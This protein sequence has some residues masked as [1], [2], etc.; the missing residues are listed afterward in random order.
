MQNTENQYPQWAENAIWYQIFPERFCRADVGNYLTAKYL[1]GTTPFSLTSK[2]KWQLHPW[3]AD[4]Y[5]KQDY[6]K[7]NNKDL[8]TNILRRRFG[9]NI[10]GIINK[11]DYLQQLGINA[12]YICPLQYSPSLHKYDGT[13]FLHTDPFFGNNPL[14]DIETIEN[15]NFDDF[16]NATFTSADLLTLKLIEEAHK[17]NIK[18]IFDGVFNHIGYNSKP[19][20]DV[21]KN[22]EKSKYKDWFIIDFEK[23]TPK[24]LEYEKFWGCVTEMPKL[25]YACN[26]VKKYVFATLKRWLRPKVNGV[27]YQGIDGWRI[28][29]AIGVPP[30]FWIQ[31]RKFV[32]K[33]KKDA[34]FLAELIEP[35]DVI[36]PYLDNNA[37][38]TV[39]NYPLLFAMCQFF[40][41]EDN[42]FSAKEFNEKLENLQQKFSIKNSIIMQNLLGSHDTERIASYIVNRKLKKFGDNALFWQNSHAEDKKYST[43]K[44]STIDIKIQKLMIIFQFCYIGAPMIYYGDEAGMWGANDPDCRKPMMWQDI[45]FEPESHNYKGKETKKGYKLEF[46]QDMFN[47]YKQII[48]IRKENSVLINGKINKIY[49]SENNRVFIF[50][51]VNSSQSIICVLN[52]ETSSVETELNIPLPYTNLLNNKKLTPKNGKILL[53]IPALTGMI[54][55]TENL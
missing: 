44:P 27:D 35:E 22:R 32:K 21:L 8:K 23:S 43:R 53:K 24:K 5:K 31:A 34:L 14:Q 6:E 54:L 36:K 7:E 17:R 51:R 26:D 19:F 3:N 16:E 28:D 50:E 55:K 52:R 12:I 25:N 13:N 42:C 40:A 48:K 10:Q 47:F 46:S 9:G 37:F 41:A 15:E 11:L 2:N 49:A 18:I 20:K 29:H 45:D 1:E 39:M 30:T 38:D 33:L 4:W